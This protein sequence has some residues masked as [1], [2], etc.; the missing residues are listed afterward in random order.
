MNIVQIDISTC[1]SIC[2]FII[3][4]FCYFFI[5]RNCNGNVVV[6][7]CN[8]NWYFS[9]GVSESVSGWVGKLP[10][11]CFLLVGHPW[12][13]IRKNFYSAE[14]ACPEMEHCWKEGVRN[15]PLT[16]TDYSDCPRNNRARL[17]VSLVRPTC[18]FSPWIF[19]TTHSLGIGIGT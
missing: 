9:I 3:L 15:S 6:V 8:C 16:D 19:C 4:L 17:L 14:G 2:N 7:V 5:Y 13:K 12:K 11:C 18:C 1:N 10:K